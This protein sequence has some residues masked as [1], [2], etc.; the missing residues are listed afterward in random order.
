MSGIGT[1]FSAALQGFVDGRNV[2]NSWE[3]RKDKNK[4]QKRLD[5]L[6]ESAETR[7][8]QRHDLDMQT[9]GL[10]NDARRRSLMEFDHDWDDRQGLREAYGDAHEA[11]MDDQ[12]TQI[13]PQLTSM[14]L[15]AVPENIAGEQGAAAVTSTGGPATAPQGPAAPV[16]VTGSTQSPT[17]PVPAAPRRAAAAPS[18]RSAFAAPMAPDTALGAMPNGNGTAYPS[19]MSLPEDRAEFVADRRRAAAAQM[20]LPEDRAEFVADRRLQASL[21]NPDVRFEDVM[22]MPNAADY[23]LGAMPA[24][25]APKTGPLTGADFNAGASAPGMSAE[26]LEAGQNATTKRTPFQNDMAALGSGI[27][28]SAA[29]WGEQALNAGADV[30]D[31][32]NAPFRAASE[33]FTGT[34]HI[35]AAPR[36]DLNND[37]RNTSIVSP[38]FDLM[39]PTETSDEAKTALA[40]ET[41]GKKAAPSMSPAAQEASDGA[42]RAM[43]AI[44]DSP[45]MQ[46]AADGVSLDD[47]GA[48]P[49]TPM[50]KPQQ[51]KMA[52]TYMQSYR[53]NGAPIVMQ[54]LLKQGRVQEAQ[55]FDAFMRSQQAQDGMDMW[56]RGVVAAQIGD[57]DTAVDHLAD[58]YNNAGYFN[59]GYE[60]LKD[61]SELIRDESGEVVGLKL[62]MRHTATGQVSTQTDSIAGLMEKMIWIT[63]P[64]MAFSTAQANQKAMAEALTKREEQRAR[65]VDSLILEDHKANRTDIRSIVEDLRE[66]QTLGT[67]PGFDVK[68]TEDEL[69]AYARELVMGNGQSSAPAGNIPVWRPGG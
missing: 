69:W 54:T 44:G 61:Q 34:D 38:V 43:N 27:K 7:A 53:E 47:L 67:L 20:S 39:R 55:E 2:R 65:S 3:D 37:G 25:Q 31:R 66:Q 24:G 29:L 22:A 18:G 62:A 26:E 30:L 23:G 19:I 46:A 68:L 16:T 40:N 63:S 5:E 45:A 8:Q 35:G 36:A 33:Y 32:V 14:P 64:E 42:T 59:D 52:K 9:G 15:G 50:S 13:G 48:K 49:G 17:T 12:R 58:A 51:K 41:T 10:L 1:A 28:N 21:G 4:R 56:M 60:V 6:A 57:I 11:A